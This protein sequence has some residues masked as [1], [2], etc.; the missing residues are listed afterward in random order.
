M[1][2]WYKSRAQWARIIGVGVVGATTFG[3]TSIADGLARLQS[4]VGTGSLTDVLVAV[5]GMAIL[6][7]QFFDRSRKEELNGKG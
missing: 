3:F 2:A 7:G 1:K 6:G 5:I 4:S